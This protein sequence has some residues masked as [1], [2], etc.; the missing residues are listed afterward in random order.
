MQFAGIVTAAVGLIIIATSLPLIY[1][2]V[3]RNDVYGIRIHESLKSDERWYEINEF[4][5]RELLK[6]GIVMIV[7]GL[8]AFFVPD[9]F[10]VAYVWVNLFATVAAILVAVVRTFSWA[11]RKR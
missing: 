2:K 3:P 5:G 4:G 8:A 6:A 7:S 11:R 9:R 10:I 1:R